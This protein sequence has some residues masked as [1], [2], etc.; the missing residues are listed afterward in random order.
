MAKNTNEILDKIC[1]TLR[2]RNPALVVISGYDVRQ[3]NYSLLAAYKKK[4]Y[5]AHIPE[6]IL[7]TIDT[8]DGYIR[9]CEMIENSLHLNK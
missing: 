1:E 2:A 5:K 3:G 9:I 7:L 4:V 6:E 8:A